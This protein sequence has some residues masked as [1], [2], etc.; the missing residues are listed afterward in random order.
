MQI[1][2]VGKDSVRLSSEEVVVPDAEQ[3]KNDR[4]LE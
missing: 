1:L 3:S 2:I 4:N